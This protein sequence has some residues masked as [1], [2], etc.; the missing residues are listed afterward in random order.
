MR[1]QNLARLYTGWCLG[2]LAHARAFQ[3]KTGFNGLSDDLA[4]AVEAA[5]QAKI[6]SGDKNWIAAIRIERDLR[7]AGFMIQR[8]ED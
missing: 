7:E 4:Q 2:F 5:I 6:D 3:N 1:E 8:I